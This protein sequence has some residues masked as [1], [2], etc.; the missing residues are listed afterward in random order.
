MNQR[1]SLDRADNSIVFG[2]LAIPCRKTNPTLPNSRTPSEYLPVLLKH[3]HLRRILQA[4]KAVYSFLGP[5]PTLRQALLFNIRTSEMEFVDR[6]NPFERSDNFIRGFPGYNQHIEFLLDPLLPP[7]ADT[8]RLLLMISNEETGA[9]PIGYAVSDC[10][11]HDTA[12]NIHVTFDL[13]MLYI[14][15]AFRSQG[16]GNLLVHLLQILIASIYDRIKVQ[17]NFPAIDQ[18]LTGTLTGLSYN[19]FSTSI[20]QH[21]SH[22]FTA[23]IPQ[24]NFTL[25]TYPIGTH[26][27]AQAS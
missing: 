3:P 25:D 4:P 16:Y 17:S 10:S 5:L 22:A 8:Q 26:D 13:R 23:I 24:N 2:R 7:L 9:N 20:Y 12:H 27:V 11:I 19:H 1:L 14:I 6:P 18:L 21:L 15:P